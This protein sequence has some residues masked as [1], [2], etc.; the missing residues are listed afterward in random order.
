M[1]YSYG[2]IET[3]GYVAAV[4]AADAMAK[5]ADVEVVRW[6]K[7]GGALV[8]VIIRGELGACRAA[9]DAGSVAAD[10]LGQ[11]I[12]AHVI[13][14]PFADT[15]TLLT[16]YL[17]GKKKKQAAQVEAPPKKT[18]VKTVPP[19]AKKS[20][21]RSKGKPAAS[22]TTETKKPKTAKPAAAKT[23]AMPKEQLLY[24]ISSAPNGI[25]LKE[26]AGQLG[27]EQAAVRRQLKKLMDTAL[28]EKVQKRYFLVEGGTKK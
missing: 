7:A 14:N 4:E 3:K 1:E 24:L 23:P 12:S 20:R 21:V 2:F 9:V 17:G 27:Q 26:L 5:A 19:A 8:V 6:K 11:L 28:V 25:T 13:P 15:H 18:P 22:A 16:R 10:R